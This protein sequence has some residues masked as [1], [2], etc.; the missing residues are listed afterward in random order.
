M[1]RQKIEQNEINGQTENSEGIFQVKVVN[2][3]NEIS[4]SREI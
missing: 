1:D 4:Y 3:D 2:F